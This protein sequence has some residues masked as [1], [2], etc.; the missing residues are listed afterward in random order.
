MVQ[1]VGHGLENTQQL[2]YIILLKMTFGNTMLAY[3]W[4]FFRI[5]TL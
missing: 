2:S 1:R 5:K 3:L 4:H